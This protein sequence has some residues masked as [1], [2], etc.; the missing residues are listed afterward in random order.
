MNLLLIVHVYICSR[1]VEN[2]KFMFANRTGRHKLN[3]AHIKIASDIL[4]NILAHPI[5]H[6]L[7]EH[8]ISHY[9]NM[10]AANIALSER[11]YN[12]QCKNI[13]KR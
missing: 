5:S 7:N 1:H 13:T 10:Y 6:Y 9:L 2:L 12:I 8:P 11:A 4:N 3:V